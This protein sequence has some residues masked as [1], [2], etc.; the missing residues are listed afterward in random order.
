MSE[1]IPNHAEAVKRETDVRDAAFLEITTLICGVEIRQMEPRD[2]LILSGIDSPFLNGGMP[3]SAD[4]VK[5][6][7]FLSPDYKHGDAEASKRFASAV[8]KQNGLELLRDIYRYIS[9]TFQDAPGGK[10][11]S[12]PNYAGWCAYLI[13]AIASEY[14]WPW[15]TIMRTPFKILYQQVKCIRRRRD[16]DAI[17]FNPSDRA[18]GDRLA[19]KQQ[20]LNLVSL[21]AKRA[22]N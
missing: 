2:F 16:P 3:V 4:V 14:G 18:T 22:R 13:D 17:M 12:G 20:R 7:W 15:Q 19:L 10:S 5:F 1:P 11:D 8:R 21:L 9:D 6:L